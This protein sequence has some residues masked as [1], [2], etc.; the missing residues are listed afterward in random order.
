MEGVPEPQVSPCSSGFTSALACRT[1]SLP[2]TV[3]PAAIPPNGCRAE[4]NRGGRPSKLTPERQARIVESIQAGH[5]RATAAR[6][7]GIGPAT[8]YRGMQQFP[9]F[10]EAVARAEAV[11]EAEL[12]AVVV[13]ATV[14]DARLAFAFLERRFPERW[15]RPHRRCPRCGPQGSL[16]P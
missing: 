2:A 16:T 13:A 5:F 11:L 8:L 3:S 9:E 1:P 4:R 10:R 15:A 14:T 6:L 12:V 7:A